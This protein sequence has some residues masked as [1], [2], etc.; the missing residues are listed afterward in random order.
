MPHC[1]CASKVGV[2]NRHPPRS[3]LPVP[4]LRARL[5]N[6]ADRSGGNTQCPASAVRCRLLVV[7]WY[8]RSHRTRFQA[9]GPGGSRFLQFD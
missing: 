5:R 7:L 8:R 6:S 1:F 2:R 3:R 9:R 4:R